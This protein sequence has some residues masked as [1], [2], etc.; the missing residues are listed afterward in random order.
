MD[1]LDFMWRGGNVARFHTHRTLS[2]D[3]VGHHSYNVACI[4]LHQR[5]EARVELITAAL[6]HDVAEHKMGDM[7]APAK[8]ALPA[9]ASRP[10]PGDGPATFREVFAHMEDAHTR[11]AGLPTPDLTAEEQWVL[12]FADSCDGMRFC[13]Q[14]RRMGNVGIAECYENFRDYVAELL[15]GNPPPH[16]LGQYEENLRDPARF[17]DLQL[18]KHLRGEWFDVHGK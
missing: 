10:I 3:F 9:Y 18:Y 11:D 5:P 2:T 6:L 4:I 1:A 17:C 12:K 8:R 15:F 7:P 16:A 14:E 13:V